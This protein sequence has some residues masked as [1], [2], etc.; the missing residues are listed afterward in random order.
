MREVIKIG[1]K[2]VEMVANAASPYIYKNLFNE[3]F[4]L[5]IQSKEPPVDLFVKMGFILSKQ[6]EGLEHKKLMDLKQD[7]F[8]TWLEQFD[9]TAPLEATGDISSFY[10]KNT[11]TNS[12]P[13][14]EGV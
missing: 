12:V 14:K 4:L 9:A 5:L 11:K 7:D 6:A 13:K 2:D 8:L 10:F 3:D 1:D